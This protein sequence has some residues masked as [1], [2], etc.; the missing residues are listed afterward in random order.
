VLPRARRIPWADLLRR[1]FAEDVLVC[2]CGGRR[3][4]VAFVAD[5]GQAHSLLITLG[6][7]AD[8]AT[9]APARDPPQTELAWNDPA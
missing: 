6:L 1:V 8:P 2:S 4:V 5:A 7:A 9:F 3:R